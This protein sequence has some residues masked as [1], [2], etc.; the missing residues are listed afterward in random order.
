M[1][2]TLA[3]LNPG[4]EGIIVELKISPSI[5]RIMEMGMKKGERVKVLRNA[6][7]KDPVEFEVMGYTI[8]LK[9]KDSENIIVEVEG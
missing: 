1:R 4:E 9:R 2:K 8:S 7:F 3:E 6:P 5:R